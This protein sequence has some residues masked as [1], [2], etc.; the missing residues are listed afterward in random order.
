MHH[1]NFV[2]CTFS[3]CNR[4]TIEY[5]KRAEKAGAS[6]ISVHGR[7]PSQRNEPVDL[8]SIKLIKENV[9]I[10]VV[11]NGDVFNLD[12]AVKLYETTGVNGK[13]F[14]INFDV[15]SCEVITCC[16]YSFCINKVL[17]T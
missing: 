10:P 1:I 13:S 9:C 5:C 11:G 2:Y 6:F 16:L 3:N 8:K 4:K 15:V 17:C 14:L 12:D 7:T